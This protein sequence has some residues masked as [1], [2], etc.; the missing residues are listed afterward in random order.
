MMEQKKLRYGVPAV[1][2]LL[3]SAVLFWAIT[4]FGDIQ[5][6]F[7]AVMYLVPSWGIAF[8][9]Y[10]DTFLLGAIDTYEEIVVRQNKA[11]AIQFLSFTLLVITG[12]V[13]AFLLYFSLKIEP[14]PRAGN[15]ELGWHDGARQESRI[16]TRLS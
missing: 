1:V 8:M 14:G 6:Q 11:Y 10:V 7:M 5:Y 3:L 15:A 4:S 12:I 16:D 13:C 9:W 2:N